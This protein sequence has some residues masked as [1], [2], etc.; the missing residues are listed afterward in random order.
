[1]VANG[2]GKR[3]GSSALRAIC[4]TLQQL[5]TDVN[6]LLERSTFRCKETEGGGQQ[7][8]TC[9]RSSAVL[10]NWIASSIK[11]ALFSYSLS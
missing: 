4:S 11:H 2:F 3:S 10:G 8:S 9:F 7:R 1:M 5:L 6:P